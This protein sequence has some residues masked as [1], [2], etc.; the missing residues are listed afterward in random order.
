MSI[1]EIAENIYNIECSTLDIGDRTGGTGY[2]DF[3]E[4]T[5]FPESFRKGSDKY[6]RKFVTV[7]ANIYYAN[8]DYYETFTTLFQRY[9]DTE[10]LWMSAG[11]LAKIKLLFETIGGANIYQLNLLYDLLKNGY[12]DITDEMIDNCNLLPYNQSVTLFM[13]PKD[14]DP[15]WKPIKITLKCCDILEN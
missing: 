6:G 9:K 3:I 10:H 13:P 2:I 5:E 8:G 12:V 15:G 4:P 1:E 11:K 14:K 7:R